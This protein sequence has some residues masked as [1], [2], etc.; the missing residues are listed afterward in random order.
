[1]NE[2]QETR[3][4]IRLTYALLALIVLIGISSLISYRLGERKAY[5]EII[6]TCVAHKIATDLCFL[7]SE[8]AMI[9]L[10]SFNQE[11]R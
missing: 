1:M 11:K 8:E 3:V 2:T 6:S 9:M 7:A 4:S 10:E 5:K